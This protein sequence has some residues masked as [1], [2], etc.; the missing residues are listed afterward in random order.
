MGFSLGVFFMQVLV[1]VFTTTYLFI[2]SSYMAN[3]SV[4]KAKNIRVHS[5]EP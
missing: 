4:Q 3:I 2:L 1:S 5:G